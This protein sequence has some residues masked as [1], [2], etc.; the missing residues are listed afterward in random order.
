VDCSEQRFAGMEHMQTQLNI[1]NN[2]REMQDSV[3][4]LY[5]WEQEMKA[6][7]TTLRHSKSAGSRKAVAPAVRGKAAPVASARPDLMRPAA[8]LTPGVRARMQCKM[9]YLNIPGT[10]RRDREKTQQS[11]LAS[12]SGYSRFASNVPGTARV[13]P[14]SSL[15]GSPPQQAAFARDRKGRSSHHSYAR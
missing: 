6:S 15:R 1:R 2:V 4:D 7:E 9:L 8:Q 11:H 5:Q 14:S 10:T 3:K 13:L 12:T